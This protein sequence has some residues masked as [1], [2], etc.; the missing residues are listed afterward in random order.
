MGLC[1]SSSLT[2]AEKQYIA[3]SNR[4]DSLLDEE[5]VA[6]GQSVKLLLLGTG[7]SGKSTIFKQM[8]IIHGDGFSD[9]DQQAAKPVILRNVVESMQTLVRT[10]DVKQIALTQKGSRE[11]AEQIMTINLWSN[12]F[13]SESYITLIQQL[14]KE[15][16]VQDIFAHRSK[17]QIMDSASYFFDRI[18]DI[19]K[20]SYVPD[21]RDILMARLR[22]SGIVEESF[23]IND[24]LFNFVDV[25]GQRSERRKWIHCFDGVTAVLFVTAI[26]E[27]DQDLF[28]E[29][30]V[31]RMR[32]SLRVFTSV[33]N[34]DI[35]AKTPFIIFF[36]KLDLFNAKIKHIALSDYFPEYT[37]DDTANESA[38]FIE[39]MY[40][41]AN[42][43]DKQY[44]THMTCATDTEQMQQ[45][46]EACRS[47][48]IHESLE[49]LGLQ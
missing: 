5:K 16:V 9:V 45:V 6:V 27:Y 22:T 47:F 34:D 17:V 46:F 14:W 44:F 20:V 18:A 26:S 37:G 31:N 42:E 23:T 49:A 32:E 29:V 48:I 28:E 36:N 43:Q 4:L 15:E 2:Q 8:M 3:D 21:S 11:M 1:Q 40:I 41:N 30:G 10:L 25:G 35:F 19:G 12:D 13:W 33:T 24:T 7:E 38:E 39:R